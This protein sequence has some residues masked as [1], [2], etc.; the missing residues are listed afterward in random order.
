MPKIQNTNL[1]EHKSY[2]NTCITKISYVTL[3]SGYHKLAKE[4]LFS[5]LESGG[6]N[7]F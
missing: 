6:F 3:E 5:W 7:D 2:N 4:I 1:D